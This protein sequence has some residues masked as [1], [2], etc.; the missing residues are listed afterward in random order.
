[1]IRSAVSGA[2]AEAAYRKKTPRSRR[3]HAKSSR[4]HINGVHHN[5]RH[6]DPYPFVARSVNAQTITDIDSN[7]YTDYWM[8]HWSLIL[9][10][11]PA[12]VR[13]AIE[14]QLGRGWM[15]GTVSEPAIKLSEEIARSVRVAQ[16]IRYVSSGTEA[17]MY[18]TRIARAY[19][20][21]SVIAKVDGGWH[22]YGTDLLKTVNWPFGSESR[23]VPGEKSIISMPYN[24]LEGSLGM[25]RKVGKDLACIVVEPVLGG[26]GGIRAEPDYLRGL[27]EFAHKRGALFVLDEIVTGFRFRYGCMYPMM[28]LDPD[29][30]TLGKIIGGGMSIGAMCGRNEIMQVADTSR[31]TKSQRAYVGG[32]TFSANPASMSAG[33]ASLQSIKSQRSLYSRINRLGEL[34][35][36]S[37]ARAF[38][39][40]VV[41]TGAGS[42]FMTHFAH[43]QG[44]I[45]SPADAARCDTALLHKFHFEMIAR[46]GIFVMPG[47]LGAVSGVHTGADIRR[48]GEAAEQ[49]ASGLGGQA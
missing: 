21:K 23:G 19:T 26:G 44:K 11:R 46:D 27:E 33:L 28:R 39:G 37:L 16:K 5:I 15:H 38:D 13:R 7:T 32:G 43:D 45:K 3:I 29:I 17:V 12:R 8:G 34:A 1:M 41:T 30:V 47:K 49:F 25:L 42:L 2:T 35:R 48:L 6:F 20:G 22:G 31:S 36:R 40:R 14:S 24:D 18:A 10:H 9:G 4:L